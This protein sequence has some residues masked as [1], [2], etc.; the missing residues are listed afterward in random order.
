MNNITIIEFGF[1]IISRIMEILE[2]VIGLDPYD[3]S[4]DT[5]TRI[6]KLFNIYSEKINID[7]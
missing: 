3:F 2:G 4:D 1:R 7:A 5:K 6:Q